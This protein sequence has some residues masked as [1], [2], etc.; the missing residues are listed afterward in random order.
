MKALLLTDAGSLE[1]TSAQC[2]ELQVDEVL[3]DVAACGVCGTDL[4]LF[5]GE[6]G[7]GKSTL[8]LIMGHEFSGTVLKTGSE[9]KDF[10][11][12]DR[13]TVD[14]NLM[15]GECHQCRRGKVQFC[16][17]A[18]AYG[19]SMD[20]GFSEQ[21]VVRQKVVYHIPNTL[22]LEHAALVEPVAC[23][24][25]GIDRANIK[26]GDTVAIIGAGSIGLI[27]LQLA[28]YSGAAR[29]IVIEPVPEKRKVARELGASHLIDPLSQDVKK[30]ISD[31]EIVSVDTVIE[32]VGNPATMEQAVDIASRGAT[33]LLFGLTPPNS[34][35]SIKPLEEVFRKE[36]IITSSFINPLVTQRSIDLLASGKINLDT[37]ITD[38]VP[39]DDAIK[40]FTDDGYRKRGK[41]LI[42]P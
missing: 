41:I 11:P 12:G 25:H 26:P 15:C 36:L 3:I 8:P 18:E 10:K 5:H 32:C 9:V 14:P 38:R 6:E 34:L 39:L 21:C 37:V 24:L 17:H 40:V 23:C 20:G 30:A 13:V 42:I 4:H 31:A 22:S 27:M 2:K 35:M 19:V 7:A 33:V 16:D 1:V 28:K 29:I